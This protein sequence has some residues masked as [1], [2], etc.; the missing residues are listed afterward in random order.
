M[1]FPVP[2]PRWLITTQCHYVSRECVAGAQPYCLDTTSKTWSIWWLDAHN[3]GSL[4]VPVGRFEDGNGTFIAHD[5]FN[6]QPIVVR[7]Q[8]LVGDSDQPRWKQA[9]SPDGGVTWETNWLMEFTRQ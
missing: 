2:E 9:F 3:P 6:G 4:D 1:D 8:W 7:F 5:T